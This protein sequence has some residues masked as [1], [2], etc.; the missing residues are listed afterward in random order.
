[1]QTEQQASE[2]TVIYVGIKRRIGAF[3]YDIILLIALLFLATAIVM[4]FTQD[5]INRGN[6][7][8]QVYILLVI[9]FFYG[10]FW[11]HGGQTLGMR[12][13]K[14]RVEL[15]NGQNLGWNQACVR[16]ILGVL[17]FG[18]GLIWCL[19]DKRHRALYD[20]LAR[21]QIVRVEKQYLPKM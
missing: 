11:V 21:T 9:F 20:Q 5:A 7:F 1:M 15:D 6:I 10:W 3:I 14:I 19:W 2:Q 17:T 18:I 12:A 13:W 16:F 8:F 4:L